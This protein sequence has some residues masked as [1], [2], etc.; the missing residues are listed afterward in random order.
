MS[1]DLQKPKIIVD[2]DW[3]SQ[4]QAEREVLA[5]KQ[6]QQAKKAEPESPPDRELPPPDLTFI[7]T[8]MYMQAL[9]ALGLIPNPVTGQ[10]KVLFQQAKHAID[11]LDILQRKTEGNRTPEE[12]EA[13]EHMLHELRLTYIAVRER[14]AAPAVEVPGNPLKNA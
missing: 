8:T 14:P 7:A 4:V 12:S 5:N 9:V 13:I 6:G 2:E 11:T 10:T 3:K 1:D